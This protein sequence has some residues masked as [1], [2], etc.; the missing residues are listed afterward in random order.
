MLVCFLTTC[1][2]LPGKMPRSRRHRSSTD[3]SRSRS[4][5]RDRERR[6]RRVDDSSRT[7]GTRNCDLNTCKT[8]VRGLLQSAAKKRK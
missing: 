3:R 8:K 7:R 2:L 1:S 6:R 4:R 5:D